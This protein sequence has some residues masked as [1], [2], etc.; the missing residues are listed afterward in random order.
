MY[1]CKSVSLFCSL[2]KAVGE[3][4]DIFHVHLSDFIPSQRSYTHCLTVLSC[5]LTCTISFWTGSFSKIMFPTVPRTKNVCKGKLLLWTKLNCTEK[6]TSNI[7]CRFARKQRRKKEHCCSN[8][9][10][11]NFTMISIVCRLF[12]G[13]LT[14]SENLI[15]FD[16]F[17]LKILSVSTLINYY[18]WQQK[19]LMSRAYDHISR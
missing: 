11:K 17:R 5:P 4:I 3:T 19:M 9:K 7:P 10:D 8:G 6:S 15:W 12:V 2:N 14:S 18:R 16:I 13:L 1:Y